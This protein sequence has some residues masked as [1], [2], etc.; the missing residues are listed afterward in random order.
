[1]TWD[2][3]LTL[4]VEFAGIALGGWVWERAMTEDYAG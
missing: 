1:M 4:V 3:W 2:L